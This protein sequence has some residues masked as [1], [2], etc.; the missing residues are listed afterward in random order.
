M[1]EELYS[2]KKGNKKRNVLI[3]ILILLILGLIGYI[4]YDKLE[5]KDIEKPKEVKEKKK[6]KKENL[7]EIAKVL[8]SKLD[9]YYVDFYDEKESFDF[10]SAKPKDLILGAFV[11]GNS[12]S[13][14]K[15][16]VDDYYNNLFGI[17]LTE[18]PDLDCWAN[19]G[20][21]AKYNE[22]T[23]E[24]E[25]QSI[26]LNDGNEISHAHGGVG[27]IHSVIIKYN[28]IEKKDGNYIVTVTKV[29]GPLN[30]MTETPENAFYADS[31]YTVKI[32]ELNQFTINDEYGDWSTIDKNAV[33]NYYIENYGKFK[34]LKPQY[35]YTFKKENN[36][37]YLTKL[38]TI[39]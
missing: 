32:S 33:E 14:T 35:K 22:S 26:K 5:T 31:K 24:Y 25:V 18:Y 17:K 23:N 10:A 15:S 3:V 39:K 21:Y 27:A 8:V 29:Y 7:D 19:D 20:V 2:Q 6:V 36:N 4:V 30:G 16:I 28:D 1:R 37:Y 38:E 11:Y 34:D 12:Y 13:L 9:K